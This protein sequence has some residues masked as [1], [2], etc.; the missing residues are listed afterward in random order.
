M[1]GPKQPQ[2]VDMTVERT[3]AAADDFGAYMR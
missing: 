1:N 3:I 2:R